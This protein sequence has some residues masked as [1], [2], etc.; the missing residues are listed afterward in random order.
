[1]AQGAPLVIER[2]R[3][4]EKGIAIEGIVYAAGTGAAEP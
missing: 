4:P 2:V 3:I 1:M